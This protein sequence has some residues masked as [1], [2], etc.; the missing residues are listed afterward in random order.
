MAVSNRH[1]TEY[2]FKITKSGINISLSPESLRISYSVPAK[3][4]FCIRPMKKEET[5]LL[6][7]TGF[8]FFQIET[9]SR[10]YYIMVR[11][12]WLNSWL[13]ILST[14][15]GATVVKFSYDTKDEAN[16]TSNYRFP[17]PAEASYYVA[18]PTSWRLD[19]RR[20]FNFRRIIFSTYCVPSK[21]ATLTPNQFIEEVLLAAFTL[22]A[23]ESKRSAEACQWINFLDSICF[24][25]ILDFSK[26]N[27]KQK[28]AF[29]LNLYHL[30]VVH[31]A[32]I[33]GPPT[34]WV[35][36]QSF[37]NTSYLLSFDV[38]SIFE[39]EF[40]MLRSCMSKPSP[41]QTKLS[42]P[43]SLFPGM[44]FTQRDFRLNFCINSS[45][46]SFPCSV[47]I[48]KPD[49][50][51]RQMDDYASMMLTEFARIDH[52]KA[53]IS[54]PKFCSLYQADFGSRRLP[55]PTPVDCLR[56]LLPYLKN[57]HRQFL[58]RL[59]SEGGNVTVRFLNFDFRCNQLILQR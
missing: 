40:N 35:N 52:Q 32:L 37:F 41:L 17:D 48:Y 44:S 24:L 6:Y 30:M 15:Y 42:V 8:S 36:W 59:V 45:S 23:A 12:K 51:D 49:I 2:I 13:Q 29:L 21:Y 4:I 16:T 22:S 55:S 11:E 10:I 18:R 57:D 1:W 50:I 7:V 47:P 3:S 26:L 43:N 28:L 25:Q 53:I 5:P 38:V 39:V 14:V 56:T 20:I 58:M 9:F 34:S 31:A 33:M 54:I 27:E 46:R 19:K